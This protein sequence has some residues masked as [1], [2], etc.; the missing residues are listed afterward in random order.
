M[1]NQNQIVAKLIKLYDEWETD[2]TWLENYPAA[3]END[4]AFMVAA[5]CDRGTKA[6]KAWE[7]PDKL[8]SKLKEDRLGKLE[9]KNI[10]T[11]NQNTLERLLRSIG[12]RFPYEFAKAIK[13]AAVRI[14]DEYDGSA[15]NIFNCYSALELYHRLTKFYGIGPKIANMVIRFLHDQYGYN[16][17]DIEYINMPGDRHNAK[18]LYRLGL[19]DNIDIKQSRGASRKLAGRNARKLD[20]TFDLGTEWCLANQPDCSGS[21]SVGE[22]CPMNTLCPKI[23]IL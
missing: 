1:N 13:S 21:E 9:P 2:P 18:V 3:N 23:G 17:E 6:Q 22:P 16:Y 7:M 11:I 15:E 14:V 4:F 8:I 20:S 5:I 19:I 12:A 10:S